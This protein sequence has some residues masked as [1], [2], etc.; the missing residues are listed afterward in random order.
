M[1]LSARFLTAL[2]LLALSFPAGIFAQETVPEGIA[3]YISQLQAEV[4][5][6][7]IHLSW[8]DSPDVRGPVY[9][10]RSNSPIIP[11]QS[12]SGLQ[13][14]VT[15]PYGTESYTD[16][17]GSTGTFYYF[18]AA[19]RSSGIAGTRFRINNIY[20]TILLNNTV[21]V[22]ISPPE[23]E[24]EPEPAPV[25]VPEPEKRDPILFIS[26]LQVEARNNMVRLTWK[27]SPDAQ[28]PVYIY[29]SNAPIDP[30]RLLGGLPRPLEVPYGVESY[31]D[32]MESSGTFYYFIAASN[33]SVQPGSRLRTVDVHNII[34]PLG[35]TVSVTTNF[36]SDF[37]DL[38]GGA[39]PFGSDIYALRALVE[40][41]GVSISYQVKDPFRNTVLYRSVQ[42]IQQTTDLL[43]AVI[44]QSGIVPPFIDYPVPGI[45]YYYAVIFEDEL[46][47]GSVGI[48]PGNNATIRAV[49]ISAGNGRVGLPGLGNEMRAMPLPLMS[50]NYAVPGI[51]S[52]SELSTPIPLGPQAARAIANIRRPEPKPVPLKKPR[53]FSQDLGEE[54]GLWEEQGLKSIV[55]G[56]FVGRDWQ[57]VRTEL[58]HFLSLPRGGI[59]TARAR[60]Y[61][62]QS[63]YF[64]GDYREALLEFLLI[65]AEF[66]REANEWIDATLTQLIN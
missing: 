28:G 6:T 20:N 32:E 13:R 66:P 22:V 23:P 60:F 62:G 9:V 30:G 61:L 54:S 7:T 41:E 31:I 25:Y 24:P 36:Q 38:A 35:N 29:R 15:V 53:A 2:S 51:D 44:V 33:A 19:S 42:P 49:E 48:S 64:T 11:D 21:A 16:E 14:P 26:D 56:P 37:L 65:K 5:D 50:L 18:I 57:K 46:T 3:P 1:P 17:L 40:G 58:N 34:I 59:T 63:L 45:S 27:D 10:Y 43:K 47:R 52:F 4:K 55:Q 39:S 8:K 12:L